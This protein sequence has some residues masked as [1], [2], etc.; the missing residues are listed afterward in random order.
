MRDLRSFRNPE[1]ITAKA[2]KQDDETG[3]YP[4]IDQHTIAS[5]GE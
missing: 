3:L 4:R 1:A 2:A 5:L